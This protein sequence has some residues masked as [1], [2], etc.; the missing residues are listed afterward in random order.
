MCKRLAAATCLAVA[1]SSARA[2]TVGA[3]PSWRSALS[4]AC[5]PS[6]AADADWLPCQRDGLNRAAVPVASTS[7]DAELTAQTPDAPSG[8]A[9]GLSALAS[10]GVYRAGRSLR[11]LHFAA[12]PEWYHT[13]GPVQVGHATPFD[14][15]SAALPLNAFARLAP[16]RPALKRCR[17][18]GWVCAAQC[19][20]RAATPR[21]P[22]FTALWPAAVG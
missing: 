6:A 18:T 14:P 16:L 11:K 2:G 9:L 13:G 4:S 19:I 15:W 21:G 10:L 5:S 22:P 12:L 8:L 1:I 7:S 17:D 20:P 3:P